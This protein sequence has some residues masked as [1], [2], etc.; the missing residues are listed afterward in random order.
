MINAHEAIKSRR[1][2]RAY[3]KKLVPIEI[4]EEILRIASRA[5]SGTNTQPWKVNVLT[6]NFLKNFKKKL[7]NTFNKE[8]FKHKADRV[9]YLE[10]FREPYLSRRRK[11]GW[12]LYALLGIKKGEYDKTKIFHAKNYEFFEAP[13]GL[14]FSIEKDL[15][16]MSWLDYGAFIQNISIAARGFDL[17]TCPQAAWGHLHLKIE[18]LLNIETN[19][20]VHCG[21]AL[22]YEDES[23]KL[24]DLRTDREDLNSFVTFNN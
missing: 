18:Q 8:G 9:H 6:G 5:P 16:W 12:D 11:I 4:V 14:I 13:V 17:H 24:N 1:S 20:I 3:K 21:M 23:N 10:K 22:G 7:V 2:V 15:G 19:F